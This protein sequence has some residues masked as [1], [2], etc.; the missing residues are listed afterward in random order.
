M[1]FHAHNPKKA[2][3]Q[4]IDL[5]LKTYKGRVPDLCLRLKIKYGESLKD[6]I[7]FSGRL[8]SFFCRH[9]PCKATPRN[10]LR[11]MIHYG[12]SQQRKAL[13]QAL[14][15]KYGHHPF[16]EQDATPADLPDPLRIQ[17][18]ETQIN[19]SVPEKQLSEDEIQYFAR[20]SEFKASYL[21]L[22]T[23]SLC[24]T[25]APSSNCSS[26][27]STASWVRQWD[28]NYDSSHDNNGDSEPSDNGKK[29]SESDLSSL[30]YC[31]QPTAE[32]T[33][34]DCMTS[35]YDMTQLRLSLSD[36]VVSG[37]HNSASPTYAPSPV[38]TVHLDLNIDIDR[39][40]SFNTMVEETF[41]ESF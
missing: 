36:M 6:F 30:I 23:A 40:P 33:P 39:S 21:S 22:D 38:G 28:S 8:R 37:L 20:V 13:Y 32:P 9:N 5:I 1:Y 4:N 31:E 19:I 35:N 27:S 2:T 29:R 17:V 7:T 26:P 14:Q 12:K 16:P 41:Q 3:T 15:L 11:I 24:S 25:S 10:M 34:P 18:R